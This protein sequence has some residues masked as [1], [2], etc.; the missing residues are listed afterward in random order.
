MKIL[1]ISGEVSPF[2][3]QT[4]N[5]E[6]M[7]KLPEL[8][9]DTGKYEIRI[10]MPRYG[11]I[12][13]RKNRLHEV[14]RLSS[15]TPISVGERSEPFTVKVASIPGIRLQVYFVDNN[16]YFKRKGVFADK[17]ES[18]FPD[19]DA[20]AWFFSQAAL[21]TTRNLGWK[22]DFVFV[23][24]W[25]GAFTPM[26]MRTRFENEPLFEQSKIIYIPDEMPVSVKLTTERATAFGLADTRFVSKELR[27]IGGI[28]AD[29]IG[30]LNETSMHH[31]P[32][33]LEWTWDKDHDAI[34]AQ[35]LEVMARLQGV[36]V[37]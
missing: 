27:E 20:R 10:V 12:N 19:N 25:I 4:A 6:L 1:F 17:D 33:L 18:V 31:D 26:L 24:G 21:E 35:T 2:T 14:I 30:Y 32:E 29:G 36:E 7:R 15:K 3:T 9:N 22:P 34:L 37:L 16:Y 28:Y 5:A 13:E 23:N 11:T 8:L